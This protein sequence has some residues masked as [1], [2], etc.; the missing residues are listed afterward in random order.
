M[1]KLIVK[2]TLLLLLAGVAISSSSFKNKID[3]RKF[4]KEKVTKQMLPLTGKFTI[5][6]G[7]D[8]SITAVGEA[9]HWGKFTF[10]S[11]DDETGFPNITGT[12]VYTVANG[13]QIFVTHTG[14]ATDLG[15]NMI[16]ADFEN[17]ITG[18]TGRFAGATGQFETIAIVS[19]I[20]PTAKGT[21][22]G[23]I[24]Y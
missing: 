11:N 20:L 21:I 23:I 9:S 24:N 17:T 12:Q 6:F 16:E 18:G 4:K 7:D 8:G 2:C 3:Q 1:K 10:I 13:D 5:T 15:N 19:E 22:N 14:Y